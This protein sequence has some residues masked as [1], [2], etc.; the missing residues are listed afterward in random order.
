MKLVILDRDGT[1]NHDRDDYIKSAAEWLP[2]PG[3]LEAIARLGF[4]RLA[5]P[6]EFT[7]RAFENGKLD[8]T[9]AEA[10]AARE[11]AST[12]RTMGQ[13]GDI[14]KAITLG[15]KVDESREFALRIQKSLQSTA[16]NL[17]PQT[18]FSVRFS[19]RPRDNDICTSLNRGT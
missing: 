4:C 3:A 5:E 2:L 11:N 12:D 1:I 6:G 13:L 17:V 16:V 10:I 15:N 19:S 18:K 8:L 7:R 14:I 9:A